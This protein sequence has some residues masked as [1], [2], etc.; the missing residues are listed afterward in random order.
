[1]PYGRYWLTVNSLHA[2][3]T[4][5]SQTP[6]VTAHHPLCNWPMWENESRE[7]RCL[8]ME[9]K[10]PSHVNNHRRRQT[11][12]CCI[13]P[14][15]SSEL[16]NIHVSCII[17]E[18]R[19]RAKRPLKHANSLICC[20]HTVAAATTPTAIPATR[21]LDVKFCVCCR[22]DFLSPNCGHQRIS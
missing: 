9:D 4:V 18:E 10:A 22:A 6:T 2:H 8:L 21:G 12:L 13:C 7:C 14:K 1:M 3:D 17:L 16:R 20:S 11:T 5:F 15:G 19:N